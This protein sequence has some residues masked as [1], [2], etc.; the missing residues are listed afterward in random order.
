M[1]FGIRSAGLE[2]RYISIDVIKLVNFDCPNGINTHSV[3]ILSQ[4]TQGSRL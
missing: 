1:P 3:M 4:N 2:V